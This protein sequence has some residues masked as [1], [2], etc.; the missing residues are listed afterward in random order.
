MTHEVFMLLSRS[1][2]VKKPLDPVFTRRNGNPVRDFRQTWKDLTLRAGLPGLLIHDFRRSAVRNMI[3]CG[4]PQ[5]V[6][7]RIS[8]HKTAAVFNRYN[9]VDEADLSDAASKLERRRAFSPSMVQAGQESEIRPRA[10]GQL[11]N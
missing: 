9:I 4:V 10:D 11:I 6:A 7:M 1:V 5:V 3:R 2:A 8:G